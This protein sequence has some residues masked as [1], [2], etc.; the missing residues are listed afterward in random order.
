MKRLA[1]LMSLFVTFAG[2]FTSLSAQKTFRVFKH[3]G[4][5][6][7]FLY[8]NIDSITYSNI[9][10]NGMLQ[11]YVVT[12]N[13]HTPDSVY[14]FKVN[15]IDSVAFTPLPT[16]YK[17]D[18]IRIEGRLRDYVLGADS[19][20]LFLKRSIPESLLPKAG[21][22]I[23][24]LECDDVLPYG[25]LGRV[26]RITQ[27]QDTIDVEC[28][29]PALTDIYESLELVISTEDNG[30]AESRSYN[31][32]NQ[33]KFTLPSLKGS[34]DLKN[35]ITAGA[36]FSG[37]YDMNAFVELSTEECTI[38][39]VLNVIPRFL[40][41][42]Q[43]YWDFTYTTKNT[44]SIGSS[45]SAELE[46]N[47]EFKI[48]SIR[49]LRIPGVAAVLEFFEEGGIF[50]NI[51]GSIGLDGSY[52]KPFTTVI[53]YT[54]N[55]TGPVAIPPTFKMI[56]RPST[57]ETTL[58]GEASISVGLYG[59]IGVGTGAEEL[60]ALE[61]GFR[62]GPKF[63]S[64]LSLTP[65]V[66]PIEVI[67]TEMYDEMDR[68][69]FFRG[70]LMLTGTVE[71]KVLND[72]KFGT[73]LE[74]GDMLFKNPF[75]TKGVVPHFDKVT[76]TETDKAGV[77]TANATMSRKLM[78]DTPVGF[79]L[80]DSNKKLV[81]HWWSPTKYKDKEGEKI[82]HD[83]ENLKVNEEYTVHPI[84]RAMK[85]NMVANPSV[86]S[87]IVSVET[88][89][90]INITNNSAI[91]KG[92]AENNNRLKTGFLYYSDKE[93]VHLIYSN[94]NG[95]SFTAYATGL[96]TG[97]KYF[98]EAFVE[99][100][101]RK[102]YGNTV[103]F[104]TK[105][106][107]DCEIDFSIEYPEHYAYYLY[108]DYYDLPEGVEFNLAVKPILTESQDS[109]IIGYGPALF[110]KGEKVEGIKVADWM[111][112]K[113]DAYWTFPDGWVLLGYSMGKS[114]LKIDNTNY[115]AEPKD[116]YEVSMIFEKVTEKGDTIQMVD[117]IRKPVKWVYREKPFIVIDNY[118]FDGS[119]KD[120]YYDDGYNDS[121]GNFIPGCDP[122]ASDRFEIGLGCY[123]WGYGG[124]W[125]KDYYPEDNKY[126]YDGSIY[127][128]VD[129][130]Q[131]TFR[132]RTDYFYYSISNIPTYLTATFLDVN[133]NVIRAVNPVQLKHNSS[134][135]ILPFEIDGSKSY[136]YSKEERWPNIYKGK[137][138]NQVQKSND[139]QIIFSRHGIFKLS[140]EE[141]EHRRAF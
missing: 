84:T 14:Q 96:K 107:E 117:K 23:A 25:F 13:I 128:D 3:D 29:K 76:L 98:C 141:I 12:Q 26:E 41:L 71:A 130:H 54:H 44:L 134:G 83:F 42:P 137:S 52:S 139:S 66:S 110:Y 103:S 32:P 114:E 2:C 67:N 105:K 90:A 57:V 113:D 136:G 82:S 123:I 40:M 6:N 37:S 135:K 73:E 86:N 109:C 78:F 51:A 1:I 28:T 124:L 138:Q 22:N 5:L 126:V 69:D 89:E 53:H 127:M 49:N 36:G 77:L 102:V 7:V 10:E 111:K 72:T 34:V 79:A 31:D 132:G 16:I 133:D 97:S 81:E 99:I 18:A 4:S 74:F 20:T 35:E 50:V 11:D 92:F 47:K 122:E 58:E 8:S 75:F 119:M 60:A 46:W 56:G 101:D 125:W 120:R 70:D 140:P 100:N 38:Y 61:A 43:I 118:K 64:S 48:E 104:T 106:Y 63:S 65:T 80:Y 116:N 112:Y 121:N 24:T 129:A 15:E 94:D 30:K 115:V 55:P 33:H 85:D 45:I 17:P 9:D 87:I 88:K 27:R 131:N 93:D 95:E 62:I 59:K 68:D 108:D 39:S 91:L 19:L 21:D